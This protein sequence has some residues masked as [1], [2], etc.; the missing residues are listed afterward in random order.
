MEA[1]SPHFPLKKVRQARGCHLSHYSGSPAGGASD[2]ETW[3]RA[4]ELA[5]AQS[6]VAS[7][8]RPGFPGPLVYLSRSSLYRSPH[9]LHRRCQ[10]A[11]GWREAQWLVG[12]RWVFF[13]LTASLGPV[14]LLFHTQGHRLGLFQV[15]GPRRFFTTRGLE[16]QEETEFMTRNGC[17]NPKSGNKGMI[18]NTD[19]ELIRHE[20]NVTQM[21]PLRWGRGGFRAF[22]SVPATA[23]A[24]GTQGPTLIW[25]AASGQSLRPKIWRMC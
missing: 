12:K 7:Q 2:A 15:L 17:Q 4:G 11:S 21:G 13:C 10:G 1:A 6:A 22:P 16:D 5:P 18:S 25:Q 9:F 14:L 3:H 24:L 19:L 20:W 23:A 8:S